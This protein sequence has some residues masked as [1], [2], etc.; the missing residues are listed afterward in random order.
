MRAGDICVSDARVGMRASTWSWHDA[1]YLAYTAAPGAGAGC[2]GAVEV[3]S[4]PSSAARPG[5]CRATGPKTDQFTMAWYTSVSNS[6]DIP[7]APCPCR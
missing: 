6:A 7:P 3:A 4:A 2:A 5:T 1:Q